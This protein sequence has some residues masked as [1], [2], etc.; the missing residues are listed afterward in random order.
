MYELAEH[1]GMS[2]EQVLDMSESE[3]SGWWVYFAVRN[4]RAKKA[5]KRNA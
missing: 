2:V 3:F 4:E 5:A 1:L